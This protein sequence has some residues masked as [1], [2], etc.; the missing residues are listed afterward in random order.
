M[1]RCNVHG[2]RLQYNNIATPYT[3]IYGM[4]IFEVHTKLIDAMKTRNECGNEACVNI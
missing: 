1:D 3:A 4:H 2:A